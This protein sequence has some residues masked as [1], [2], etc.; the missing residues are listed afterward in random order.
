MDAAL[1]LKPNSAEA[2]VQRG[3]IERAAGDVAGARRDF[4]AALKI[5]GGGETADAARKRL[6]A[7]GRAAALNK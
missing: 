5:A 3:E 2:L 4:Q 1:K 6:G 7:A